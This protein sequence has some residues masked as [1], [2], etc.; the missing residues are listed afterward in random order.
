MG[1]ESDIPQQVHNTNDRR[2][3]RC[4]WNPAEDIVLI[5]AWLNISKNPIVGNE[6]KNICFLE[7]NPKWATFI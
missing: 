6:Q 2:K 7:K 4:N 3:T 1:G 5:S